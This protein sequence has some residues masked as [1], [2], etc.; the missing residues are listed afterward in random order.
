[1]KKKGLINRLVYGFFKLLLAFILVVALAVGCIYWLVT[2]SRSEKKAARA[3]TYTIAKM[4]YP[5]IVKVLG[6]KRKIFYVSIND[7]TQR[8]FSY[9][10]RTNQSDVAKY[11][12]Y[13]IDAG[14][15]V[16]KAD[17]RWPQPYSKMELGKPE[18][19]T[20]IMRHIEINNE[21]DKYYIKIW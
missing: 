19:V 12:D 6:E 11:T 2:P 16:V 18:P 10:S 5:S 9:W 17:E 15:T 20:G 21:D 1:M 4:E 3:D 13:L 8:T 14:F 7:S